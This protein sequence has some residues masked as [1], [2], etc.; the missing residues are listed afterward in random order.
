[1]KRLHKKHKMFFLTIILTLFSISSIY[2]GEKWEKQAKTFFEGGEYEKCIELV[3]EHEDNKLARM[4]L[5]FSHLQEYTFKQTKYDKEMFKTA[6]MILKD[7]I[8]S[9]DMNNLLFFINQIDQP[10]VVKEARKLLTAAFKNCK[11]NE[12][13]LKLMPFLKS[14]DKK[15]K[16]ASIKTIRRII[17]LKRKAVDKGGTLRKKDIDI[18]TNPALIKALIDNILLSKASSQVLVLIEEPVLKYISEYEGV[19]MMDLEADINK[20]IAKRKK[21]Y[22]ASNWYSATGKIRE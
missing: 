3:K 16:D 14:S 21:K 7:N 11:D 18:M 10:P 9:E 13:I 20:A 12:D 17:S 22:P 5:A 4:F 8:G 15:T 2:A 19:K 6:M 1:M